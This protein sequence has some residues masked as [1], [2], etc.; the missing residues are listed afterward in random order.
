[1]TLIET[2]RQYHTF[3]AYQLKHTDTDFDTYP[4]KH[5]LWKQ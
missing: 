3:Q 5:L 4:G 1:M 2:L